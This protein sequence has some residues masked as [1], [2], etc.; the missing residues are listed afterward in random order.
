[1]DALCNKLPSGNRAA[2]CRMHTYCV[3]LITAIIRPDKLDDVRAAVQS[4][5]V[6]GLTV[7]TASGYGRARGHTE[8]YRGNGHA[9]DLLPRLRVE[10]LATD[11]EAN[12]VLE[13]VTGSYSTAPEG[14]EPRPGDG[15]VWMTEVYEVVRIR[16]RKRG[17]SAI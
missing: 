8:F 14:T 9:V 7:S 17:P 4:L 11:Q 10:I 13:G 15:R 1:M 3:K 5:G 12:S 2:T 16:T 6:R